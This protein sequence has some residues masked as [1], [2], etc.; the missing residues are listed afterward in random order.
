MTSSKKVKL[1]ALEYFNI[2][3]MS[4][5]Y[6]CVTINKI[7]RSIVKTIKNALTE[8]QGFCLYLH[9]SKILKENNVSFYIDVKHNEILNLIDVH[10]SK[11]NRSTMTQE[12]FQYLQGGNL[13]DLRIWYNIQYE[14]EE[15]SEIY[16]KEKTLALLH[17]C[18]DRGRTFFRNLSIY[19]PNKDYININLRD[20]QGKNF[21]CIDRIYI[22]ESFHYVIIGGYVI[23]VEG[24][25]YVI[26][27]YILDRN[28]TYKLLNEIYVKDV[29]KLN[30]RSTCQS[31]SF[32]HSGLTLV[33]D[34]FK[35]YVI[36]FKDPP[37]YLF[38]YVY[39]Y[40]NEYRVIKSSYCLPTYRLKGV[41]KTPFSLRPNES[42]N[43]SEPPL[44]NETVSLFPSSPKNILAKLPS[45]EPIP[46][47]KQYHSGVY[48][49]RTICY[50]NYNK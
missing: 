50:N 37:Y 15:L 8:Y 32:N 11:H 16:D 29:D 7:K 20:I 49:L 41:D 34:N 33:Y 10:S 13:N 40:S 30:F 27:Y 44:S 5:E 17:H 48:P 6:L 12:V 9:L 1:K 2:K 18:Q 46:E 35:R 26:R 36:E 21:K 47:I 25:N 43:V 31:I 23:G 22:Y 28:K 42:K 4:F 3:I 24:N 19:L 14:D 38:N 39:F 45:E